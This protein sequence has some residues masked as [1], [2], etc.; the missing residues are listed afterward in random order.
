MLL[1]RHPGK[2]ASMHSQGG[3]GGRRAALRGRGREPWFSR[4]AQLAQLHLSPASL[5]GGPW[6]HR[7]SSRASALWLS[8]R[9]SQQGDGPWV[10]PFQSKVWKGNS[11]FLP[12]GPCC[13]LQDIHWGERVFHGWALMQ[14]RPFHSKCR[15]ILHS[16]D[17]PHLFM[18]SIIKGNYIRN[19]EPQI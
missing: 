12:S 4:L 19:T 7:A 14:Q 16:Y 2:A 6:W 3:R 8:P 18:L 13:K 11:R 1:A 9:L 15:K 10:L 17:I 5:W